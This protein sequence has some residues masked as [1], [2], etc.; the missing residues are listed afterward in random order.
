MVKDETVVTVAVTGALAAIAVGALATGHNDGLV[1]TV[2]AALAAFVGV[3]LGR[4]S[5]RSE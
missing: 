3:G 1:Q 4:A 5:K 2:V